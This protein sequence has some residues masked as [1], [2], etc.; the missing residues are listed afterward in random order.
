M[1]AAARPTN[2]SRG[3]TALAGTRSFFR[4]SVGTRLIS[5]SA[6]ATVHSHTVASA[7]HQPGPNARVAMTGSSASRPPAGAGTPTKN[8]LAYGGCSASS[9]R[10]LNRA[11]R[12]TMH[13]A[14]MSAATQPRRLGSP[15]QT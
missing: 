11:S 2:T 6:M 7:D 4:D 9:S 1:A 8:S 13:T 3:A 12:S 15:N 14:K 5:S 10:V